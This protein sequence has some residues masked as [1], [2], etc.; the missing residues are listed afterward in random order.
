[1][2]PILRYL[3][4]LMMGFLPYSVAQAHHVKMSNRAASRLDQ[5]TSVGEKLLCL[6]DD[7]GGVR[8]ID[9]I[10]SHHFLIFTT[11]RR[12]FLSDAKPGVRCRGVVNVQSLHF[13]VKK[14]GEVCKDAKIGGYSRQG[15]ARYCKL[16]DF[17]EVTPPRRVR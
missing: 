17:Q 5:Y 2:R 11:S 15:G 12:I 16:I 9:S 4:I 14:R 1:M 6:P 10:D 3:P 13:I 8:M 7:V